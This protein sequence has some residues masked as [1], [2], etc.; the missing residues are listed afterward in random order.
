M[1]PAG[2]ATRPAWRVLKAAAQ[3]GGRC[4]QGV[5]AT[6]PAWRVLKA[7][8]FVHLIIKSCRCSDSTRLEGTERLAKGGDERRQSIVAATRPAWRVLK[9]SCSSVFWHLHMSCSDSTRFEGTE[10]LAI[11]A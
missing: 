2:A 1:T 3:R 9:A 10:R 8:R 7:Q 6:R 5:A 11:M 4:H